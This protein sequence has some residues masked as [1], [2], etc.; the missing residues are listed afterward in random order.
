MATTG[1]VEI[2]E[3]M[4]KEVETTYL[5]LIVSIMENNKIPKLMVINLDQTPSKYVPG[6][7]KT[8]APKGIKSVSV[9]GST[10]NRTITATFSITIDGKFLPMLIIYGRKTSKSI[11]PVSFPDNFLVSVNKKHYNNKKESLKM[12]EHIII[13]YVKKQRQNLSLNPSVPCLADHGC[14]QRPYDKTGL[15]SVE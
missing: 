5:H 15:G 11:P 13:S 4:Q 8:L 3:E 6:Y 12:L 9:S 1:K 7:N 10:D 2:S 14:V